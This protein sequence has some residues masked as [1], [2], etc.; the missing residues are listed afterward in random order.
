VNGVKVNKL[1]VI[2]VKINEIINILV[3]GVKIHRY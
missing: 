3:N 1:L 2:G